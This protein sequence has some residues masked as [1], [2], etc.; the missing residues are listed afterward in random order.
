MEKQKPITSLEGCAYV[1]AVKG[2]EGGGAFI[3]VQAIQ[4]FTWYK[5]GGVQLKL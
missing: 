5:G 3:L 4:K 1:V 2:V